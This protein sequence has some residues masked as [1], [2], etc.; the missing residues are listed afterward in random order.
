MNDKV[1]FLPALSVGRPAAPPSSDE[2][3]AFHE[4]RLLKDQLEDGTVTQA[5]FDARRSELGL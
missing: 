4:L 2:L 5:E 1:S 3:E